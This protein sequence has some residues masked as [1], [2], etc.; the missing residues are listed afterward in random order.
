MN[1]AGKQIIVQKQPVLDTETINAISAELQQ[2]PV[3]HPAPGLARLGS[4]VL[5]DR[6]ID[7]AGHHH[8]DLHPIDSRITSTRDDDVPVGRLHGFPSC[9]ESFA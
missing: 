6:R 8:L 5:E 9:R 7:V 2:A 4:E 3:E 1:H